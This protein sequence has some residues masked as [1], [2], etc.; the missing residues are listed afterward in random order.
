MSGN[1]GKAIGD[2]FDPSA[3]RS[4]RKGKE[5]KKASKLSD[6]RIRLRRENIERKV[7]RSLLSGPTATGS[8]LSG[9][10][11]GLGAGTTLG[12]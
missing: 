5:R 4:R 1:A 11:G 10:P 3:G 6:E 2:F 9:R 12:A 7:G 8:L